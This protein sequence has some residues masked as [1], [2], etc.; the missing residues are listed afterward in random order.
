[1]RLDELILGLRGG[2]S[3]IE[4]LPLAKLKVLGEALLNFL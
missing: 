2:R 1:M 3:Q 4:A